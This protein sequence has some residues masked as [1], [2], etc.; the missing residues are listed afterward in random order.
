MAAAVAATVW[1]F[2][3][4]KWF[5]RMSTI[6][7]YQ[8]DESA[9]SRLYFWRLAWAMALERPL[10]GAGF[11]WSFDPV[12][13]DRQLPWS[14]NGGHPLLTRPRAIHSIWFEML[15]DQGF[16]GFALFLGFFLSAAL[17]TRWL[18]RHTRRR[19]DLAWANH[20]G[21]MLQASLIAFAVGGTFASLEFYDF[22]YALVIIIAAARRVAARELAKEAAPVEPARLA[23]ARS[24]GGLRPRPAG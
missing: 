20:L 9:E 13:V 19:P 12:S 7:T 17:D 21:R 18:I 4:Q 24:R 3:P 5:A 10:T 2:A 6:Q 1:N 16:P 14:L 11:H 8:Q 23:V 22:F 15:S